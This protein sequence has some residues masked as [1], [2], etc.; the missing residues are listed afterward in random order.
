MRLQRLR[1]PLTRLVTSRIPTLAGTEMPSGRRWMATRERVALA[2]NY[3]CAGC[4]AVWI[5]FRDQIDHKVPRA[6]GGSN[7]DSNLQPLCDKCHKEKTAAD[8]ARMNGRP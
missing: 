3:S 8:I 5:P 1:P 6:E 7:D 2:H 4:G